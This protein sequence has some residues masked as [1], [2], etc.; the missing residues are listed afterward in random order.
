MEQDGVGILGS[1]PTCNFLP[2]V[3]AHGDPNGVEA[4]LC[5][6]VLEYIGP[7]PLRTMETLSGV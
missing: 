4:R 3:P 6:D 7:K 5:T 1:L 2:G